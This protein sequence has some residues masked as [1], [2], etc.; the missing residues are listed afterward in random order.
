MLALGWSGRL[1][2]A[3]RRASDEIEI[4]GLTPGAPRTRA[5]AA[6]GPSLLHGNRVRL[7]AAVGGGLEQQR[8]LPRL[9]EQADGRGSPLSSSSWR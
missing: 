9:G 7:M 3:V 1:L 6:R 2:A 5:V 4:I 8:E